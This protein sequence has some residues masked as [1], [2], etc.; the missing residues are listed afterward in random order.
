M[1]IFKELRNVVLTP[2]VVAFLVLVVGVNPSFA[3]TND[4][5]TLVEEDAVVESEVTEEES[6]VTDETEEVEE[7]VLLPGD[8]FYFLKT[9]QESV[10]LAFTFDEM[11]EAE[12]LSALAEERILEATA[13][14]EQGDEEKAIE[15]LQLAID[16]QNE[17]LS[18]YEETDSTE[19]VS[20]EDST[21]NEEGTEEAVPTEEDGTTEEDVAIEDEQEEDSIY[22]ELEIK[23][24]SN[25]L[26]LQAAFEKVENPKAKEALA[27]N[28]LKAQERLVKKIEKKLA[29]MDKKS[30]EE[31][32]ENETTQPV[33]P[34][35]EGESDATVSE[36]EN[37]TETATDVVQE[38]GNVVN[39]DSTKKV[40]LLQQ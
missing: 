24:S 36:E 40:K 25:L 11:K 20:D 7:P 21:T 29:K 28:V 37:P 33:E 32:I 27:K 10:Q 38:Q 19:V 30:N 15:T 9:L 3:D 12:L 23:F 26:A 22:T 1:S 14:F 4:A 35:K 16:Q 5:S 31:T 18:K 17:A 39:E 6:I 13:L 34:I 2:L 8:F